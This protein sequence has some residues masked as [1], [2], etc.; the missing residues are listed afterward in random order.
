MDSK[1]YTTVSWAADRELVMRATAKSAK[2]ALNPTQSFW[3]CI[4]SS[5][6]KKSALFGIAG[7]TAR[8]WHGLRKKLG[9]QAKVPTKRRL[10]GG[11]SCGRLSS[12]GR[13]S[14]SLLLRSMASDPTPSHNI[15]Q[16]LRA[17][18][19]GDQ[20]AL[21]QLTPL[22]Y[23][24]LHSLARRH[25]SRENEGHTLQATALIHEVYL[26]LVEF[27]SVR[28]QDRAHFYAVC[29][30]LMRR[31]LIDFARSHNSLKRGGSAH[32]L[33][34][35]EGLIVSADVPAELTDLEQAL[36]KL[37]EEDPRKSSVV[38]LRFFGGLTVK[39]T[40]E[41]LQVSPATVMRDWSMARA[42]L[43][44]EMDQGHPHAS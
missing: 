14:L 39:E 4:Q 37:A 30:R 12:L 20:S 19:E 28:W 38:E 36:T 7:S 34:L 1:G 27:E 18:G 24:E 17:W 25:M 32:K 8:N 21:E 26:K 31:I 43:L 2:A 9:W 15:T 6:M 3:F 11:W 22:V 41:A 35:E 44:R 13:A 40:A 23:Q 16:L 10:E 5:S 42:W 29:A 33:T